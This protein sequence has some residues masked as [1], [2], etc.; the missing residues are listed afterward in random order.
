MTSI[1]FALRPFLIIAVLLLVVSAGPAAAEA[2]QEAIA[3]DWIAAHN[4]GSVETMKVHRGKHFRRSTAS[5]WEASSQ[6]MFTRMGHL[7]VHGI[8]IDAANEVQI[9]AASEHDGR[10]NLVF[11]FH[12]DEPDQIKQ[13]GIGTAGGNSS[14]HLPPLQFLSDSWPARGDLLDRYLSDLAGQD[15][16]SGTVMVIE[17][18]KKRFEG[19]YGLAS[20][21]F[22]VPNNLVTR[23]DVG[24]FNKDYTRVAILQLLQKGKLALSD[25]VGRHLPDYPNREVRKQ[26]TIQQLLDHTSGLGDYFTE[27]YFATPMRKLREIFRGLLPV[28]Q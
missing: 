7:E 23:F 28:P 24:S 27:E 3:L 6:A 22:E 25:K 26:V 21:E 1:R 16:F 19:A 10:L 15:V 13:V 12:P 18:G 8:M 11:S 14:G 5:D 2:D 20:R 9:Q 4:S 17:K